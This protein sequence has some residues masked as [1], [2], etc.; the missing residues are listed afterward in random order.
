MCTQNAK[1][2][3]DRGLF[4]VT[5]NSSFQKSA[6][7]KC[8]KMFM[9]KLAMPVSLQISKCSTQVPYASS[10]SCTSMAYNFYNERH[11]K[12]CYQ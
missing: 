10:S 1:P 4:L 8:L 7:G 12:P 6:L 2:L 9:L 3:L 11:V 5:D